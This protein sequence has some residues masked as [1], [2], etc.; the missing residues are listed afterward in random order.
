MSVSC[1]SFIGS[2]DFP[3]HIYNC[4]KSKNYQG[5]VFTI[6]K[7]LNSTSVSTEFVLV[8]SRIS[9]VFKVKLPDEAESE[10]I[11]TMGLYSPLTLTTLI[12]EE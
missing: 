5:Q 9:R 6:K 4:F 12:N 10:D 2:M 7:S 11:K 1:E 8:A 3:K